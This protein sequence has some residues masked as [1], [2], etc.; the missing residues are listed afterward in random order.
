VETISTLNNPKNLKTTSAKIIRIQ[1]IVDIQNNKYDTCIRE[2]T[3][4]RQH[5]QGPSNRTNVTSTVDHKGDGHLSRAITEF[6]LAFGRLTDLTWSERLT[7]LT[8]AKAMFI[9]FENKGSQKQ[10]GS[11]VAN[12]LSKF[13]TPAT[14]LSLKLD[15]LPPYPNR[16]LNDKELFAEHSLETAISMLNMI[17]EVQNRTQGDDYATQSLATSLTQCFIG[18]FGRDDAPLPDKIKS[19]GEIRRLIEDLGDFKALEGA[20]TP[21]GKLNPPLLRHIFSL[22][23]LAALIPGTSLLSFCNVLW[24]LT[25]GLIV[26]ELVRNTTDEYKY[27]V[28]YFR[29]SY[30]ASPVTVGFL[31]SHWSSFHSTRLNLTYGIQILNIFQHERQ[32]EAQQF[33]R[34]VKRILPSNRRLL[35]HGSPVSNFAS[36]LRRGLIIGPTSGIFFADLAGKSVGFC[37]ASSGEEAFMLLCEVELGQHSPWRRGGAG[38]N[39][40]SNS[41]TID[42]LSHAKWCDA[43]CVHPDLKGVQ[44]PDVKSNQIMGRPAKEYILLNPAQ[45]RHRYIFHIKLN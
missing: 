22:L 40:A 14:L 34:C 7:Q 43:V 13:V 6:E 31:R 15:N 42:N 12:V 35:W 36:I 16:L 24:K 18:L 26:F 32:G 25:C 33:A 8:K 29:K 10:V 17:S 38:V 41:Y 37:R 21:P 39:R 2:T 28:G 1:L 23:R 5:P 30:F 19:V 45:I 44:I 9:R 11:A 20:T 3:L 4:T 27:L